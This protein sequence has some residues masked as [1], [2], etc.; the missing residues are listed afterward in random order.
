MEFIFYIFLGIVAVIVI[1]AVV[2]IYTI[3]KMNFE[4]EPFNIQQ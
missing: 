4:N 3:S 1:T 2:A